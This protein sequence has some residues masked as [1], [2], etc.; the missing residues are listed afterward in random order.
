MEE[1]S[2]NDRIQSYL[3]GHTEDFEF[4]IEK[5]TPQIYGFLLRMIKS[6]S[7]AD[8]ITQD[9]FIKAWRK[10]G[11]YRVGENFRGWLFS[12][13]H[14]SAID[15]LRKKKKQFVFSDFDRDEENSFVESIPDIAPLADELVARMQDK[16]V[17]EKYLEELSPQY[18]EVLLLHYTNEFTF[19]EIGKLL[20]KPLNTVKSQHRRALA[21]LKK[22]FRAPQNEN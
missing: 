9:T 19:D 5:Y 10:I 4:L 14:N 2:D 15:W 11:T 13:A 7:D 1:L 20:G 6:E 18:R 3:D 21:Q 17:V 22:M 16:V 8:D 12:I